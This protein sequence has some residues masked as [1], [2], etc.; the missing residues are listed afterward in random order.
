MLLHLRSL[1]L[2]MVIGYL[3]PT[4][5]TRK[6]FGNPR[7][8]NPAELNS[9]AYRAVEFP[10]GAGVGQVR[11]VA[12]AYGA[13]ASDGQE[14]GLR[15]ETLAALA[16]PAE[17]PTLSTLDQVLRVHT[18]YAL[19]FLKPSPA[20]SF[21]SSASSYGTMGAGGS[22]GFADPDVGLGFAYAP[23]KM[24]FH[25]WNDPREKALRDAVYRCLATAR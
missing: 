2:P 25:I 20:F 15:P 5:L 11:A 8:N 6:A 9:P 21:G 1:P 19:G 4:S 16:R 24:G 13:F 22:F 18:A 3:N 14:V 10:A 17:P 23:N 12:R 7:L